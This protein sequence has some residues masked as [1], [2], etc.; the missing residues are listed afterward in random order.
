MVI[1][2]ASPISAHKLLLSLSSCTENDREERLKDCGTE[3]LFSVGCISNPASW[4]HHD[5]PS[6]HLSSCLR[7]TF[8]VDRYQSFY[9]H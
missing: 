3:Q 5:P 1:M 6:P 2:M 8:L 4:F 9:E 7:I